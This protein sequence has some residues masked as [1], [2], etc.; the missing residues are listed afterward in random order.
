M[1]FSVIIALAVG[2]VFDL[3]IVVIF[4]WQDYRKHYCVLK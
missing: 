1:Y 2:T 3:A 4:N